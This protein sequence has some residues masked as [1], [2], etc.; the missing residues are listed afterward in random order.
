MS[1]CLSLNGKGRDLD[2]T[3]KKRALRIKGARKRDIL[4]YDNNRSKLIR[5]GAY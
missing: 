4:G 1:Q 2:D 5:R 3:L